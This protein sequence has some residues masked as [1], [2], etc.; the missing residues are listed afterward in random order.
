MI[1]PIMIDLVL[2]EILFLMALS[3]SGYKFPDSLFHIP[4]S[5]INGHYGRVFG[6]I[7]EVCSINFRGY[8]QSENV[9]FLAD[10]DKHLGVL[11]I[12]GK[13]VLNGFQLVEIVAGQV[14]PSYQL[15]IAFFVVQAIDHLGV[16]QDTG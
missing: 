13:I 14:K 8:F 4:G 9:A 15:I 16:L 10:L 11:A 12:P 5:I 3:F 7:G 1:I 6:A 2:L